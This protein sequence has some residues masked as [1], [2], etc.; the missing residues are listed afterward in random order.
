MVRK[1]YR[2]T[3]LFALMILFFGCTKEIEEYNKPASYWYQ[4]ITESIS[5]GNI[6][7]A[8]SY[9]SSLQGEH[10]GS[11]LLPEATLM[12][13]IAHMEHEEYLLS[14]HFLNEYIKRYAT[15]S[16]KE[17]A[18]YLKIKAKYMA[19]PNP[20]RDQG[21][22]DEAIAEAQ[23]FKTNYPVSQYNYFVDT[24]LTNLYLAQAALNKA[25]ADL[26][27]RVD[28]TR[29]STYYHQKKAAEWI[30]WEEVDLDTT[31]WYRAWFEGDG[32]ASW[33]GFVIPNTRSVVSRNSIEDAN[34]T[35]TTK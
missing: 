33:Y 17:F 24:M 10:I 26:Y 35:Q 14:E 4:K 12:L 7:A 28:K 2:I 30:N 3:L 32:T 19:L 1:S 29:S 13:A 8:D 27:E 5:L 31:P 21:L 22:I 20:R 11:P 34:Q 16:Q 23:H 9:Y 25:I 6:E 15:L 18:E